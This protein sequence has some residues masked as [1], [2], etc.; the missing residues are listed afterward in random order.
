MAN[1]PS[2]SHIAIHLADRALTPLISSSAATASPP[3][4]QHQ[5]QS[6]PPP[7]PT[8]S[9]SSAAQAQALSSL[10]AAAITAYDSASRLDLGLPQRILIET[11]AGG[12]VVLH[13]FLNPQQRNVG[14]T[15]PPSSARK[16]DI[17]GVA[18]DGLRP[19]SGTTD[20]DDEDRDG[21][22]GQRGPGEDEDG[23]NDDDE[24]EGCDNTPDETQMSR[25]Q[26]NKK[27]NHRQFA[28]GDIHH[29]KDLDSTKPDSPLSPGSDPEHQRPQQQQQS[30]APLLVA[31]V[32][33]SDA[34]STMAARRAAARLERMGREVQREFVRE[35][36]EA[37][38]IA[39]TTSTL[40]GGGGVREGGAIT[41]GEDG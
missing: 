19:L 33:A 8:Q 29:S 23:Q 26:K 22:E 15:R 38:A 37:A 25:K 31:T 28:N 32:V 36:E 14:G 2:P 34:G 6:Q 1:P 40:A 9:N 3:H 11:T 12:P 17:V 10:T 27:N 5:Q 21:D 39:A 7:P 35:E 41:A 24:Q 30:L 20:E 13:S 4:Q 18:R 16:A